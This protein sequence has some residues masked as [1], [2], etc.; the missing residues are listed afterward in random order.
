MVIYLQD[1]LA[2]R[3]NTAAEYESRRLAVGGAKIAATNRHAPQRQIAPASLPNLGHDTSIPG[4]LTGADAASL[5]AEASL[6]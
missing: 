5:Y 3:R 1:V 6:I 2:H 4:P